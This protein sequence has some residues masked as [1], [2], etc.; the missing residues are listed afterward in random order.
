MA[1]GIC[2]ICLIVPV[3]WCIS[4]AILEIKHEYSYGRYASSFLKEHNLEDS[5]IFASWGKN[6]SL[7]GV[8]ENNI[9]QQNTFFVAF[10]VLVNAYYDHNICMNLNCGN[11][12]EAYMHYKTASEEENTDNITA[13]REAGIPDV[14]IGKVGIDQVYDELSYDDYTLVD[15]LPINYIWK[16]SYIESVVPVYVRSDILE[17]HGLETIDDDR[18]R[19]WMEGFKITDE[20]REQFEQGVSAEEI[21]KP[22]L[23]AM[24]GVE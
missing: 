5:L 18:V 6:D 12:N 16:T 22:Y 3:Y 23:D 8:E 24:F 4:S 21:L 9:L 20:M 7:I 15:S 14:I 17:E 1:F 11:D 10:P 19:L 13:W 2:V